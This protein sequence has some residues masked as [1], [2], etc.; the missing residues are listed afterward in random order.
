MPK[1]KDLPIDRHGI[2]LIEREAA[3]QHAQML[4]ADLAESIIMAAEDERART[5]TRLAQVEEVIIQLQEEYTRILIDAKALATVVKPPE[6]VYE[7]SQGAK[8]TVSA[9]PVVKRSV[10]QIEAEQPA[11]ELMR[12]INNLSQT[13]SF[14]KSHLG[15]I[16]KVILAARR[17][18]VNAVLH[19]AGKW[20]S[21]FLIGQFH[22]LPMPKE[23]A[24]PSD[25][26]GNPTPDG[27]P[28]TGGR[29]SEEGQ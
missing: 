4:P 5:L 9:R 3:Y 14:L 18:R 16:Q 15:S 1:M 29:G 11:R 25:A 20:S 8:R 22:R 13:K 7:D 26:A 21:T 24:E 6:K 27:Q 12:R 19:L 23:Q 17:G 10:E 28:V 2:D